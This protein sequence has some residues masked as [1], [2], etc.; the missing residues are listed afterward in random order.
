M[1]RE[2]IPPCTT[3]AASLQLVRILR[4]L[5]ELAVANRADLQ[6]RRSAILGQR[7]TTASDLL[8]LMRFA[9][10]S[11]T[12][13]VLN[14]LVEQGTVHPE[15]VYREL[16]SIV[17]DLASSSSSGTLRAD[18][19]LQYE[20]SK[21]SASLN[22][23]N[24]LIR[25]LLGEVAPK[26][27]Y[28]EIPL[29]RA[30]NNFLDADL[31]EE[32]LSSELYLSAVS[33]TLGEAQLAVD[34]PNKLRISAPGDINAVLRGFVMALKVEHTSRLPAGIPVDGQTSYFRLT[35]QGP[36]WDNIVETG[37]LVI[38]VPDDILETE[39]RLLS[40]TT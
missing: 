22:W 26:Q 31:S 18:E 25:T 4:G 19:L 34:I 17:G 9:S 14:H 23:L 1:N 35:K 7:E 16:V 13:P 32:S 27:N 12:I 28:I 39:I 37:K 21:P 24:E 6:S 3:S 36:Y 29:R 15:R 8:L 30:S 10:L 40:I 38:F 11:R 2:F 5:L 33:G 20:H